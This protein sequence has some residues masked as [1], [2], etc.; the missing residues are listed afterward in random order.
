MLCCTGDQGSLFAAKRELVWA[1]SAFVLEDPPHGSLL[2]IVACCCWGVPQGSSWTFPDA[3]VLVGGGGCWLTW[4]CP[5]SKSSK[6][7]DGLVPSFFFASFLYYGQIWEH[8]EYDKF[9]ST[10]LDYIHSNKILNCTSNVTIKL[11]LLIFSR[12]ARDACHRI[13]FLFPPIN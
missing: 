8:D 1:E 5:K 10:Y 7:L 12:Q 6:S 2:A 11:T 4:G 13:C 3:A 9:C